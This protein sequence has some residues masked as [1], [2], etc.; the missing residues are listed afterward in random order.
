M[1]IETI[2]FHARADGAPLNIFRERASLAVPVRS[3]SETLSVVFL[4]E[5]VISKPGGVFKRLT[6][7]SGMSHLLQSRKHLRFCCRCSNMF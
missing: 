7:K 3:A 6:V 2:N 5:E 1:Q 4:A